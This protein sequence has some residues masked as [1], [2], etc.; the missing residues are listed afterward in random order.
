V[1]RRWILE[2]VGVAAVAVVMALAVQAFVVKPFR[3]PSGSMAGTLV[4]RDRVLVNRVVYHLRPP[5][6]GDVVVL[7][8]SAVG[9]IL[10]KRVVALPGETIALE[11]GRVYVD[12]RRLAEPYVKRVDGR[13]EAT[14]PFSGTEDP[15]SL[16][17]PF[18][19][20]LGHYFLMGDNRSVS[21]DSRDWGPAPEHELIGEAFCTYWPLTRVRGL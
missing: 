4:P 5:H 8:S 15:W 6:R 1:R 9:R 19:V 10:I 14:L 3:I 2:Y 17:E 21:D 7:D 18:V 13:A 11:D 16:D 12:G 20:P